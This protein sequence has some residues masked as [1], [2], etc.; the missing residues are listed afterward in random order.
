MLLGRALEGLRANAVSKFSVELNQ[1]HDP[2]ISVAINL[3]SSGNN[4]LVAGVAGKIIR[5]YRLFFIVT[6][7]TSITFQ[8]AS[9]AL[10]GPMAFAANGGMVLDFDTKPWFTVA[11]GDS[12]VLNSTNA[13]Q[14]S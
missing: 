1:R 14:V 9:T 12:W 5:V 10:T 11:K 6:S 2:F 7:S 13:V 4:T 3:N 8:D